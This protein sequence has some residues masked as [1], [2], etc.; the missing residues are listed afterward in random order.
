[1]NSISILINI[2]YIFIICNT[3]CIRFGIMFQSE[4]KKKIAVVPDFAAIVAG[5]LKIPMPITK[6][7]TIMVRLKKLMP[8]F[9]FMLTV[10][11]TLRYI[12]CALYV[13]G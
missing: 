2:I 6:L 3:N 9:S 12:I 7:I 4:N 1:M 8:C 5:V 10:F 11:K 13:M